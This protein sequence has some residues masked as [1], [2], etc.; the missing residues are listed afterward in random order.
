MEVMTRIEK[1]FARLDLV[2]GL[3][4]NQLVKVTVNGQV[5]TRMKNTQ[6][7]LIA[8]LNPRWPGLDGILRNYDTWIFYRVLDRDLILV[9]TPPDCFME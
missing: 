4:R 1:V 6:L 2:T 7:G 3:K 5:T 9:L 8:E